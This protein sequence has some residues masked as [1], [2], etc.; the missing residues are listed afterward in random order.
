MTVAHGVVA[1][2]E[3]AW[4]FADRYEIRALV[5]AGGMGSVYKAFDL[6]LEDLVALKLIRREL[7]ETPGVLDRFRQEVKLARRVTHR[8]VARVYDLGDAHG[9]R[10]FTMELVE[11]RSLASLLTSGP[12]G[13]RE[14]LRVG[15]DVT[16][17]L[18][19][20]HAAGVIHRDLKPD[21]LLVADD[22]RVVIT[23][24][25]I[26]RTLRQDQLVATLRGSWVGT[27]VYM[28]PESFAT[29]SPADASSDLFSVGVI[30]FE[31]LT[32]AL[33]W[34]GEDAME[35][36][37][38]RLRVDAT[39]PRSLRTD[40]PE[41]VAA[42]VLKC[43]AR[44]RASRFA[45][46]GELREALAAAGRSLAVPSSP[47]PRAPLPTWTVDDEPLALESAEREI[48]TVAVL[49][50]M[51]GGDVEE[52]LSEGLHEAIIGALSAAPD[53]RVRPRGMVARYREEAPDAAAVA[54]ELDA[55]VVV[56][57]SLARSG[58]AFTFT[59]RAE[60]LPDR[61]RLWSATF[62]A[63]PSA[64]FEIAAAVASGLSAAMASLGT[65]APLPSSPDP[66]VSDLYL[67]ARQAYHTFWYEGT[68]RAVDL[69]ERA[70]EAAPNDPVIL[71]AYALATIRRSFFTGEGLEAA[72]EAAITA[73]RVAPEAP[74]VQLALASIRVQR[75]ELVEAVGHLRAALESDPSQP[76]ANWLLGRVLL[77]AG[78]LDAA[79]KRLRWA[80]QLEPDQHLVRLD[81]ARALALEKRWEE[82]DQLS[83]AAP[84]GHEAGNWLERARFALWRQ[85]LAAATSGLCV[86]PS[87]ATGPLALARELFEVLVKREEPFTKPAFAAFLAG[88]R[89]TPRREAFAAQIEAEVHQILGRRRDALVAIGRATRLGLSDLAW[90]EHCP[91]LEPL[92]GDPAFEDARRTVGAIAARVRDAVYAT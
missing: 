14:A 54:A 64:L 20:A 56:Q 35:I 1:A 90:L 68:V 53:L 11:G 19:A 28:S 24:F 27:P 70:I 44:D 86:V 73:S 59:A 32:G 8:N 47:P 92:R 22:G 7:L 41:G 18:E 36:A 33:P 37:S 74:E 89:R 69:L 72:R 78:V 12:L 52:H 15:E 26:A 91:L 51:R 21:N 25:G 65:P 4:V 9:V 5:G 29:A 3:A 13:V 84:A 58:H 55:Q 45:S 16:A 30:L 46:A 38:A 40:I 2:P 34:A 85:D 75:T 50:V 63:P 57:G 66:R 39:D 71:A 17:G 80:L 43:L 67:R 82:V 77:E 88:A 6:E 10:Y 23:D 61:F 87:E 62:T 79:V 60:S 31:A 83:I 81:L 42:L 48:K 76:E 49:P